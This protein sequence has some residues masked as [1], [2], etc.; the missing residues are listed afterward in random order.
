MLMNIKMIVSVLI[1]VF[2]SLMLLNHL[3]KDMFKLNPFYRNKILLEGFDASG[4]ETAE[5]TTATA[6]A[7]APTEIHDTEKSTIMVDLFENVIR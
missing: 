2:L 5:P 3:F 7:T 6:P 4:N 1:M